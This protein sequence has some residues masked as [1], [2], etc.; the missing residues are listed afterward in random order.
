MADIVATHMRELLAFLF[1]FVLTFT[2][3]RHP[4][5]TFVI[6]KEAKVRRLRIVIKE[7]DLFCDHEVVL[8][9]IV[10]FVIADVSTLNTEQFLL[11]FRSCSL[12]A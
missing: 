3:Y 6:L 8:A 9:A 7:H 12:M 2:L 1:I 4:K 5:R 10:R 11:R